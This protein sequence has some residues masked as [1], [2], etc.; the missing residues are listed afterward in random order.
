MQRV[1]F[2]LYEVQNQATGAVLYRNACI[3]KGKAKITEKNQEVVTWEEEE[4]VGIGKAVL[5]VL[6]MY[7][8][9]IWV[10]VTHVFTL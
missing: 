5:G 9:L 10:V 1:W 8:F 7:Y 6:G 3:M 2:Y 4:K